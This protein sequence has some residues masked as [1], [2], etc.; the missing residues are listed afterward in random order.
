MIASDC[1]QFYTNEWGFFHMVLND[2]NNQR[3]LHIT[4]IGCGIFDSSTSISAGVFGMEILKSTLGFEL[5]QETLSSIKFISFCGHHFLASAAATNST[6][7]LEVFNAYVTSSFSSLKPDIFE[8]KGK[9]HGSVR[10][11]LFWLVLVFIKCGHW[12][13]MIW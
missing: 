2:V 4:L 8:K 7:C 13:K 10:N 11:H 12:H 6:S 5:S 1:I 3:I 9:K